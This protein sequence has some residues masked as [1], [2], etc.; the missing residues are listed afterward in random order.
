[1][2]DCHKPSLV[3]LP[4]Q[5]QRLPPVRKLSTR[6][7][8]ALACAPSLTTFPNQPSPKPLTTAERRFASRTSIAFLEKAALFAEAAP[9]VGVAFSVDTLASRDANASDLATGG[10]VDETQ[11]LTARLED[12]NARKTLKAVRIARGVKLPRPLFGPSAVPRLQ[13]DRL[14]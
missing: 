5:Q 6:R 1:M 4:R 13:A 12:A 14:G 11:T 2:N 10:I 3:P 7:R 8:G 9:N